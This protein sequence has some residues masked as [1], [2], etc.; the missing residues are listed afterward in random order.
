MGK[1]GEDSKLIYDLADQVCPSLLCAQRLGCARWLQHPA[2]NGM[3]FMMNGSRI[4][5]P[6]H[7]CM[8]I[9][10]V[11]LLLSSILPYHDETLTPPP[12]C[13]PAAWHSSLT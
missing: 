8:S 3:A 10:Y 1:Y 7:P 9:V 11:E 6:R 12:A 4:S 2:V 13:L 5:M